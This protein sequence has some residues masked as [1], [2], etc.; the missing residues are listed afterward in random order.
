M[1][2]RERLEAKIERRHEWA[3]KRETKAAAVF[4]AHEVY[5]GDHAFNFQPGH[6]PERARVIARE[7]RAHESLQVAAHHRAKADGLERQLDRTVFSDDENAT[8]A[9][10]AR[11]VAN[12]AKRDR[13]KLINKLYRKGDAAGLAA[14]GVDL[15]RLRATVAELPSYM[16]R[17]PFAKYELTNLGARIR[18]DRER[19]KVVQRRQERT[20]S[21]EASE[22]GASTEYSADR[23]Y[24]TITFAEKPGR[25]TLDALRG[26]GSWGGGAWTGRT[27][28]LP[29]IVRAELP[30]TTA[31]Q[32]EHAAEVAST[33]VQADSV[34][35]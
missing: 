3:D 30:D 1:T 7:D 26:W 2:R 5:V 24:V 16:D 29:E 35:T 11:A 4:K 13:M 17:Q 8:E 21:A 34:G 33:E 12:E 27:E 6:I 19:I 22:T 10:E 18:A 20:A 9:L 14:I 32:D 28:T 25:E 23:E 15:E 31:C